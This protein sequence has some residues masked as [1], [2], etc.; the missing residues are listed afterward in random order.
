MQSRVYR[1]V[2]MGH[3]LS[4]RALSKDGGRAR[5]DEKLA[6]VSVFAMIAVFLRVR[7]FTQIPPIG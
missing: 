4:V 5:A 3:L 1:S 2:G 7:R 6:G